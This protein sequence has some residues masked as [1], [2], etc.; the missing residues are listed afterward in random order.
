MTTNV[1]D[2]Q[3]PPPKIEPPTVVGTLL[4]GAI[5]WANRTKTEREANICTN[6]P[7]PMEK[8]GK[9]NDA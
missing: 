9:G 1:H 2:V 6:S 3:I 5:I 7:T 4:S 8:G